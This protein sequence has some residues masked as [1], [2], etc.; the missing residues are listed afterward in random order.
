MLIEALKKRGLNPNDFE[1]YITAF[2]CGAPPH[3][4][5]SIGLERFT[6]Q[7][8]GAKNIRECALFPRDR[9]RIVP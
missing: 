6:M 9:N 5:W 8:T 3:A 2:K 7:L 4:G 1:S